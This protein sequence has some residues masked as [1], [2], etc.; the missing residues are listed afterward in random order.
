MTFSEKI[1]T[2]FFWPSVLKISAVF[3][4]A[5]T[6]IS[7]LFESFQSIISFDMQAIAEQNFTDGKWQ[8]FFATKGIISLV[9]GIWVTARNI[10]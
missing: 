9:Y 4:I 7:L 10:K 5:V 8:K 1:K 2:P 6:I 3:L